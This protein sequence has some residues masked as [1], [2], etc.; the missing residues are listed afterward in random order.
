MIIDALRRGLDGHQ[1]YVRITRQQVFARNVNTGEQFS[2]RARVGIDTRGAI[3]SIGEPV[4]P[5]CAKTVD[6]FN[7]PRVVV[8]DY[9]TAEAL[10]RF[11][12]AKMMESARFATAPLVVVHADMALD[13]GLSSLEARALREMAIYAGARQV[14]VH[15]GETLSD[16]K[17]RALLAEHLSV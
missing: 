3:R 10:L 2:C 9:D 17:A 15:D 16:E 5:D 4:A 1:L 13:G 7:H 8:D 11:V 6:P 14:V 12:C